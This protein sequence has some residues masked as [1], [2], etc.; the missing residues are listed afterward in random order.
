MNL[1]T[2]QIFQIGAAVICFGVAV[3]PQFGVDPKAV[4]LIGGA[5]GTLWGTI[6]GILT[7]QG[8]Q[9]QSVTQAALS[10]PATQRAVLA[11]VE[12]MRGVDQIV[13]NEQA[14]ATVKSMAADPAHPKIG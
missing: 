2:S 6:G 12:K 14:N 10:D 5:F 7:G 3:A 9:V 11:T 1:T 8:A 4:S 13:T